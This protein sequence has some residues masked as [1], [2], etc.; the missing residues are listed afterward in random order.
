M[1]RRLL[2]SATAVLLVAGPCSG[3]DP[4]R[5]LSQYTLR[6]WT[7]A[8]GLPQ[9][10]VRALAQ[11]PD[12]CLWVGTDEGLARFDGYSFYT[13]P[14]AELP[15]L[16]IRALVAGSDGTLWVGTASGLFRHR[17]GKF[18]RAPK[19]GNTP[20]AAIVE[21]PEG[22]VW[23]AAGMRLVRYSNGQFTEF[24]P[25]NGLAIDGVRALLPV[26][27]DEVVIAGYGA[28]G[29]FRRGKTVSA[30]STR[31]MS[32]SV[33][34]SL[35]RTASGDLLTGGTKG[36][37]AQGSSGKWVRRPVFGGLIRALAS[38]RD[39][40]V[41]AGTNSGLL[42]WNPASPRRLIHADRLA[43]DWI[44]CIFE[45]HE[46]TLW[47]GSNNGLYQLVDPKVAVYG[48]PEGLP[49]DE[50]VGVAEDAAGRI[51]TGFHNGGA[52]YL[53]GR[54]FVRSLANDE[55]LSI[56]PAGNGD[57][58]IGTRAGACRMS[59]GRLVWSWSPRDELGRSN[60]FDL[61][62]DRAGTMWLG[63]NGGLLQ[64][65]GGRA[66]VAAPG[67][68]LLDDAVVT[69][70]AARDG[71]LWAGT[72]A[73]GL[74]HLRGSERVRYTSASGLPSDQ[75]RSL[76]EDPDGVVWIATFGGGLALYRSGVFQSVPPRAIPSQNVGSLV[77]DGDSLWLAT[78]RG[79]AKV[80]RGLLLGSTA[81]GNWLYGADDG[82]RSANAAPGYPTSS[83]GVRASDGS[84]WFPTARG[85]ARFNTR[86]SRAALPY[87]VRIV[88]TVAD[89]APWNASVKLPPKTRRIDFRYVTVHLQAPDSVRYRFRLE[90]YDQNWIEAGTR[91]VA[92]YGSLRRGSYRFRV[93]AALA[94]S[95]QWIEAAALRF[96]KEPWFYETLWFR[97]ALLASVALIIWSLWGYRLAQE[98]R[99]FALVLDERS[100]LARELHDTLAQGYVGIITQLGAVRR[101]LRTKPDLAAEQIDMARRMAEHSLVEAR[102]SIEDLRSPAIDVGDFEPVLRASIR[103][104]A[105]VPVSYEVPHPPPA[106]TRHAAHHLLRIAQEAVTNAM[107]H[108]S[109]SHITVRLRNM[110]GQAILT[111]HDD[112]KGFDAARSAAP[113]HF[114]LL[115]MRER[116]EAIGGTIAIHS[117]TGGGTTIEVRVKLP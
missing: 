48:R 77:G 11:T 44:W 76:Y 84:V 106:L 43:G 34:T 47:I 30:T 99:R 39:G 63:T 101:L 93:A 45:D 17:D 104:I 2:W 116:A 105:R 46:G 42:R 98:R 65:R 71:A 110:D 14:Q 103:Q 26:G 40:N 61:V 21:G 8:R 27:A 52:G 78:T 112:G 72:F 87:P 115:G 1:R 88:E 55:V 53:D 79:V 96:Q 70:L 85:L 13:V 33:P 20:V 117:Q 12:G 75:I 38:D 54:R 74:W 111:I 97:T 6:Y 56:R 69:I 60:V 67:G 4:S 90:P 7:Q 89:G 28:V 25:G 37:F 109:P 83:G 5:E 94:G 59:G 3:L 32:G 49:S 36:L 108:A 16:S 114:G 81:V 68:T 41:W 31:E 113:G 24:G 10:S 64:L 91:R 9:D 100:R 18:N 35:L 57:I 62:E 29:V 66:T 51:W 22:A 58:L 92:S 23:I 86:Q 102:R 95:D 80:N 19:I 73:N 50:P 15:A 82:L 107:K